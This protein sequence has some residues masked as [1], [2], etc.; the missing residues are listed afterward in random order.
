MAR[1]NDS[2][3]Y[4][5]NWSNR[6]LMEE[7]KRMSSFAQAHFTI[8]NNA[9]L[10]RDKPNG[11][12]SNNDTAVIVEATRLYRETWLEPILEEIERRFVKTK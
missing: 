5:E 8:P 10:A 12:Y 6:K 2:S 9:Q 3:N 7:A 1:Y 11:V 4:V